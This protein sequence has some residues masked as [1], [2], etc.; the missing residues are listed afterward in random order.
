MEAQEMALN[1]ESN[2]MRWPAGPLDIALREKTKGFTAEKAEVLRNWLDP[3]TLGLLQGTPVN[4]LVVSW[5][6]GLPA[7]SR[8]AAGAEAADREGASRPDLGFV[9]LIE[10]KRTRQPP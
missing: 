9:G 8:P 10:A 6:S 1:A 7:D 4:S 2:P 3:A 5:A